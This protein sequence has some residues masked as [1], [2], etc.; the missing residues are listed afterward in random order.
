MAEPTPLTYQSAAGP[1]MDFSGTTCR[2]LGSR[3]LSAH[4]KQHLVS[5]P[6]TLPFFLESHVT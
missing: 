3:I 1:G 5:I 4:L 2:L 6:Q